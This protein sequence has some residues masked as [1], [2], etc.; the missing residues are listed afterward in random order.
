MLSFKPALLALVMT[1][2]CKLLGTQRLL[3]LLLTRVLY[4]CRPLP[5]FSPDFAADWSRNR[6]AVSSRYH[7]STCVLYH[8]NVIIIRGEHCVLALLRSANSE[9][10]KPY[11]DWSCS[12]CDPCCLG[13]RG[14]GACSRLASSFSLCRSPLGF[15]ALSPDLP[16]YSVPAKEPW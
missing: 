1:K 2:P 10:P 5:C 3:T 12:S 8:H 15:L 13:S 4:G 6:L 11:P 16:T 7:L 14:M 9:S